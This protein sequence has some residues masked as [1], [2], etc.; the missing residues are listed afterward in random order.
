MAPLPHARPPQR[1]RA[2]ALTA[3]EQWETVGTLPYFPPRFS[4]GEQPDGRWRWGISVAL[5]IADTATDVLRRAL[6]V[7]GPVAGTLGTQLERI[8]AARTAIVQAKNSIHATL[9]PSPPATHPPDSRYWTERIKRYQTDMDGPTGDAIG[10]A[11]EKI[12]HALV[13]SVNSL[14]AL[15]AD[16]QRWHAAGLDGWEKLLLNSDRG[17]LANQELYP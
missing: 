16:E 1:I 4:T 11:V 13:K 2:A 3:Q 9:A 17:E 5:G 15:R 14:A 8:C 10:N 12:L 7:A 6:G